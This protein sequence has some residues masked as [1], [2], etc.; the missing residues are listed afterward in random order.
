MDEEAQEVKLII[1]STRINIEED[2]ISLILKSNIKNK[3]IPTAATTPDKPFWGVK[4]VFGE[5]PPTSDPPSWWSSVA[6]ATVWPPIDLVAKPTW[7]PNFVANWP[8]QAT[9]APEVVTNDPTGI[10]LIYEETQ[11]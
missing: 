2:D 5:W 9:I 1:A 6:G 4:L 7:W 11:H 8:L 3:I 10:Q